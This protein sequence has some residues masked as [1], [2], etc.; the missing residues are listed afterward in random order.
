MISRWILNP[1]SVK[2]TCISLKKHMV[3]YAPIQMTNTYHVAPEF[4]SLAMGEMLPLSKQGE[5][6][7][8]RSVASHHDI[9]TI[10]NPNRFSPWWGVPKMGLPLHH[11]CHYRMFHCKASSVFGISPWLWKLS[12]IPLVYKKNNLGMVKT[13][14][15]PPQK[16]MV[17]SHPIA[18]R[19]SANAAQMAPSS[20]QSLA[21]LGWLSPP[22]HPPPGA[23]RAA[24]FLLEEAAPNQG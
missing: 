2:I 10:P 5:P 16:K 11:P 13:K 24:V 23:R 4:N 3:A 21:E 12:C 20:S 8:F 22:C 18:A 15:S 17:F 1:C 6:R 19:P 9:Y 7:R 14:K